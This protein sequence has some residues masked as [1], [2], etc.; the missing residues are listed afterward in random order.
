MAS[1]DISKYIDLTIYDLQPTDIYDAGVEYAATSLPE[2]TPVPGSIEDALLQANA[3]MTGELVGAINR[4]PSGVMEGL[5]RLYGI[6]RSSGTAPTGV[7]TVTLTNF[8]GNTL[9]SGTTFGYTDQGGEEPLLFL[10]QTTQ[11]VTLAAGNNTLNVPIQGLSFQKYPSLATGESLQLLSA[12]SF[13]DSI[14][15]QGDLLIGADP[16]TDAQFLDRATQI[17]GRFSEAVALPSQMERYALTDFANVY[18]AHAY[19]RIRSDVSVS[20]LDRVSNAVTADL[21]QE[22]TLAA[23]SVVRLVDADEGFNGV[24]T[25]TGKT[26]TEVYWNQDGTN[27]S[28]SSAGTLL[29]LD[30]QDEYRDEGSDELIPQTGYVTIYASA[31]AGGSLTPQTLDSLQ[32]NL[33]DRSLIGLLIFADNAKV[34]TVEIEVQVTKERV[35]AAST[36]ETAVIEALNEYLHPDYWNWDETIYKN[37]IIALIDRVPGVVRVID[38]ELTPDGNT[39]EL[40]EEGDARIRYAGVLPLSDITV[41]IEA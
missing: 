39:I 12:V 7:A 24:F 26:G 17:L 9:P 14:V 30:L 23:G 25:L 34:A 8:D 27:A 13:V 16:E 20:S 5:L 10:F 19:S 2:W 21:G 36:V 18:R 4:L 6:L 38:V 33:R 32:N 22:S 37:E 28:A 41:T 3:S 1:P 31:I 11:S 15:L 35:V 29:A 40:T